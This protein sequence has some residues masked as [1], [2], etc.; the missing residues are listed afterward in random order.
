MKRLIVILII[1]SLSIFVKAQSYSGT[2]FKASS[3]MNSP[4][5]K[6]NNIQ[7]YDTSNL[8]RSKAFFTKYQYY[9]LDAN[10]SFISN[11]ITGAH[12]IRIGTDAGNKESG[13]NKFNTIIGY[14]AGE[15]N[16]SGSV[17]TFIGVTSG[18]KTTIGTSNTFIGNEAGLY[19]TTGSYNIY[20]GRDA[21]QNIQRSNR[22][23]INSIPKASESDDTTKSLIYGYMDSNPLKQRLTFNAA[24]YG[25]TL[26]K[27][28]ANTG[29]AFTITPPNSTINQ[30]FHLCP[31]VKVFYPQ[32]FFL[33]NMIMSI[34]RS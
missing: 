11:I 2:S 3:F 26:F 8:T 12:S 23:V 22:F 7:I 17:N 19:N 6:L 10:Y 4:M 13:I 27:M 31:P 24:I 16:T 28:P 9:R 32:L 21:G 25:T 1:L 33:T 18:W 20:L 29:N 15:E 5:Y 34:F 30:R 14:K